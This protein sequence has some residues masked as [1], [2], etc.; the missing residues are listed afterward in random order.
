MKKYKIYEFEYF[1]LNQIEDLYGKSRKYGVGK[2][3]SKLYKRS[4][5]FKDVDEDDSY[6]NNKGFV[7]LSK[8][9]VERYL[10]YNKINGEFQWHTIIQS[11]S[12][13]GVIKYRRSGT[14]PYD[15]KKQYWFF[16]LNDEFFS[17]KKSYVDIESKTLNKW[18]NKQN[19]FYLNKTKGIKEKGI[20]G[21]DRFLLYELDVCIGTDL[22]IEDLDLVID[23]RVNSKLNEYRE[24][25]K[26]DWLGERKKKKI[27]NKLFDE[28]VFIDRYRRILKQKYNTIQSDLDNLRNG[29]YFELSSDYFRRDEFGY[30][31]YNIYSRCVREFRE[32]IKIDD[33]ATVEID[34]KNSM[35]SIFYYFIKLLNDE[36]QN[37]KYH[38]IKTIYHKLIQLN[39]GVIDE[40]RLGELYLERWDYILK[41]GDSFNSDYYNFLREESRLT[42]LSRNSFKELLW[43]VLFG[44]DIQLKNLKLRQNN[45]DNIKQLMLGK[46]RWLVDDLRS[47]SLYSWNKKNYKYYKNI[48]LI[49]HTLERMIMDKVSEVMIANNYKYI[50]IFDSFIVKQSEGKEI[51]KL[52]NDTVEGFDK[53]FTFRLKQ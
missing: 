15:A 24:K 7:Y 9:E 29:E 13:R 36:K 6:I 46:S 25:L 12:S 48:S 35:I 28:E 40:V 34:L 5:V 19:N 30:R 43:V 37:S 18:I 42:D 26:W 16:R 32:H 51:Q 39:E 2:F 45:Y 44:K 53:V 47:I 49:L 27:L 20:K 23:Q 3:L 50:S 41:Y 4:I 1:D 8:A 11:L 10:G 14:N 31:I 22:S 21:M 33:E 52:L 17:C 38:L